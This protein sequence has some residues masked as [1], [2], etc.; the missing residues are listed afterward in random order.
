MR[1]Q[2][3]LIDAVL[4]RYLD[5]RQASRAVSHAYGVW[6]HVDREDRAEA[7]HDYCAALDAE[8]RAANEYR[9]LID[10]VGEDAATPTG[11]DRTGRW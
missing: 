8:E 1:P 3:T 7:Y 6:Q 5:W 4:E 11:R 2:A 10:R 9:A